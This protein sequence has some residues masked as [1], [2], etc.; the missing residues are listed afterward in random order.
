[1]AESSDPVADSTIAVAER[2]A[3]IALELQVRSALIGAAA[4][5]VHG[6]PRATEDLDL[7][8][9]ADP[10][11]TLRELTRRLEDSGLHA[12][13]RLPDEDDPLGG[14]I[15]VT[16]EG[17]DAI[18]LVNYLNPLR[19]T[20]NPGREAIT[21]A[22]AIAGTTLRVV[23]VPHL[24]AL[25]L[26]AGGAKSRLDALELLQRNPAVG[27]D[28]VRNVCARHALEPELDALLADLRG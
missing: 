28:D 9:W 11:S 12:E 17:F 21:T 13:I 27:L 22:V 20:N 10:F 4:L 6:Y 26:Y 7:A 16:G 2:V 8:V 1:M 3:A 18:Q 25:K 14:V 5:A 23:D 19:A 24:V 15:T